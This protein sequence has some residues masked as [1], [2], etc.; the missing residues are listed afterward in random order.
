MKKVNSNSFKNCVID[1][2]NMTITEKTKE[3]NYVFDLKKV[4]QDW[5][6]IE[7]VSITI[8]K[9]TEVISNN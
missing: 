2:D 9:D 5:N 8:K 3:D 4:L 7:G 1:V 6:M